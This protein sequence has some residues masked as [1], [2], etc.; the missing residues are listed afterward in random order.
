MAWR[1]FPFVHW[2]RWLDA[3]GS[4]FHAGVTLASIHA[5]IPDP[6]DWRLGPRD[7]E[8]RSRMT[9]AANDSGSG[10][11]QEA[12]SLRASPRLFENSLLDKFSRVHWSTPLFVYVPVVFVLASL[13]Q[14]AYAARARPLRHRAWL[15]YL[16]PD[17]IFR[18]PL[19]V[20]L[21]V[22]QPVRRE[23]SSPDPW[24]ASRASQ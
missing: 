1:L 14:Q 6:D 19:P 15:F 3:G 20:P 4:P 22:S 9:P 11:S 16:D 17:R 5:G 10:T 13:S 21:R 18:P 12:A 24:R 7:E 8:D 23:N 2:P